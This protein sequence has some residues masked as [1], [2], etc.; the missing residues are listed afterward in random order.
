MATP[1]ANPKR[2]DVGDRLETGTMLDPCAML[3]ERK[4]G[5]QDKENHQTKRA[6]GER[7]NLSQGKTPPKQM[8]QTYGWV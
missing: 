5:A 8:V 1:M 3:C 7:G 2:E 4:W 6:W